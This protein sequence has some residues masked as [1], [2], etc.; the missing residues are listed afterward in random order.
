[1]KKFGFLLVIGVILLSSLACVSFPIVFVEG[2]AVRGSGD[3]VSEER[4]V[5]GV[6]KVNVANQGDLY[7]EIGDEESLVIEAEENLMEYILSEVRDGE[8]KLSTKS[9]INLDPQ[10]PIRYY[11]TVKS[12]DA[13]TT[14]SAGDIQVPVIEAEAFT[15]DVNSAGDVT[16]DGVNLEKLYVNISSAGDVTIEDG[17]AVEQFVKNNSAGDYDARNVESERVDITINSAGDARIWVTEE[18]NATLN[19][20]GDLYYRGDPPKSQIREKSIGDAI[21]VK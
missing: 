10:K 7:I 20:S 21:E 5:E 6:T 4:P 16:V 15:I 12:L 2:D 13:V 19:S 3:L 8:L 1:M 18:L 14:S 11:L 9:R 17:M